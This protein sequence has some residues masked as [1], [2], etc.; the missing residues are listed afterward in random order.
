MTGSA[1]PV[2]GI[3]RVFMR[4]GV[5]AGCAISP[6]G[7]QAT[8]GAATAART[9]RLR[10]RLAGQVDPMPD[11]RPTAADGRGQELA[12]NLPR[13]SAASSASSV[14]TAPILNSPAAE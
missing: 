12:A 8:I 3:G 2:E 4:G 9:K 10:E 5:G 6:R 11:H 14:N 7:R 1:S 13:A